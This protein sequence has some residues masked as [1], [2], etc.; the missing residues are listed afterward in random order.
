M[1]KCQNCNANTAL[2]QPAGNVVIERRSKTY[3]KL[4]RKG[5]IAWVEGFEVVKE[6]KTCPKCYTS[7]TGQ[8]APTKRI[9]TVIEK[10]PRYSKSP[11]KKRKWRNPN[12]GNK[13]QD[14]QTSKKKPVVQV[15]NP[16]KIEMN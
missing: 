9:P 7:L 16:L 11:R 6:I 2:G 3:K 12:M 14:L 13:F 15:I 8:Q 10:K 4:L 5:D 1:F